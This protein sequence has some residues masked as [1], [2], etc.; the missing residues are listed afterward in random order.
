MTTCADLHSPVDVSEAL[1]V[2]ARFGAHGVPVAALLKRPGLA[3]C[4]CAVNSNA[5]VL[6]V[7]LGCSAF[8]LADAEHTAI[9]AGWLAAQ[10]GL[11]QLV[12]ALPAGQRLLESQA[13]PPMRQSCE[14]MFAQMKAL[15]I[16]SNAAAKIE[17]ATAADAELLA[18]LYAANPFNVSQFLPFAERFR[19]ALETGRFYFIRAEDGRAG[20][21]CHTLPEATGLGLIMGVVTGPDFRGRGWGKALMVR[22]CRDLLNDGLQPSLFY[23]ANNPVTRTLYRSLGFEDAAAFLTIDLPGEKSA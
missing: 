10:C 1:A 7:R 3:S 13:L 18:P 19:L 11:T 6:I 21:A 22:L 4:A 23:E 17:R 12:I 15:Q 20:G 8:A 14:E 9:V 16:E 2:A 5:N